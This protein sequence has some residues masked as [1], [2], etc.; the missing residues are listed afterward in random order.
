MMHLIHSPYNAAQTVCQCILYM[1]HLHVIPHI[2]HK[3]NFAFKVMKVS[4]TAWHIKTIAK[5]YLGYTL[6]MIFVVRYHVPE[7]YL[8]IINSFVNKIIIV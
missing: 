5:L 7:L 2:N 4:A 8:T 3:K 6:A 1:L